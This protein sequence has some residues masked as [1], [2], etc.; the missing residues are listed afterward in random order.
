MKMTSRLSTH[1]RCGGLVWGCHIRPNAAQVPPR[2]WVTL[3]I[4]SFD[5]GL[6]YFNIAVQSEKSNNQ[7]TS[8]FLR[9]STQNQKNLVFLK[10]DAEFIVNSES[11][12]TK[13]QK[14]SCF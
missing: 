8:G 4:D 3:I 12:F 5:F 10:I 13:N 7:K 6:L 14:T 9:I 2:G 11:C 1:P